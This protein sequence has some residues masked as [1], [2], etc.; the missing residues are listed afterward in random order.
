MNDSISNNKRIAKNTIALYFRMLFSMAVGFYTSRVILNILGVSDYGIYNVVGSVVSLFSFLNGSMSLSTSRF[1]TFELG[2]NSIGRYQ[3]LFR[4]S[5]TIHIVLAVIVFLVTE[6]GGLW[7]MYNKMT[8][9]QERI[10]VAQW[11]FHL[12]LISSIITVVL[13]PYN[14]AIIA[15]EKM[16]AFAWMS[17]IDV[18]FKLAAVMMLKVINYDKLITY[19]ILILIVTIIHQGIIY[20]YGHHKLCG[21]LFGLRWDKTDFR[22]LFSFAG[23]TMFGQVAYVGFTQGLNML[24]NVFFGPAVNAARGV[25]VQVQT[26]IYKFVGNIQ[27][28]FNPQITKSYASNQLNHMHTLI[29]ACS[30]FSFFLLLLISAPVIIETPYILKLWLKIVP[31][32]TVDFFRII[33][34]VS[35][36]DALANPLIIS[37][38]ATGKVKLWNII[39]GSILLLIVPVSYA[40]LEMGMVAV[41]VFY[42]H[43]FCAIITQIVR[44]FF[45]RKSI[46]LSIRRYIRDVVIPTSIV[47]LI[48]LGLGFLIYQLFPNH[49]PFDLCLVSIL[50]C[51]ICVISIISIGLNHKERSLAYIRTLS[52]L[53]R[54]VLR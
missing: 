30:K 26:I 31:D 12:S 48:T 14:S 44:L 28:A 9:P 10:D 40:C 47:F 5:I 6:V 51:L 20:I 23:W 22:H 52:L 49:N 25:A 21:T 2:R 33:I 8:L 13:I 4:T 24:L 34:M 46:Q 54:F 15:Y 53:K 27:T 43:L 7:F 38:M 42:V 16:T 17:I 45:L 39:C 41:T 11:V 32:N 1:L 29:F 3:E 18:T 50:T 37:N 35:F 36:V 19:A